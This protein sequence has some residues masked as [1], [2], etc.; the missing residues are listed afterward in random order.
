MRQSIALA[1]RNMRLTPISNIVNDITNPSLGMGAS[2][3][4]IDLSSIASIIRIEK[5]G[6]N[7]TLALTS[8]V[9]GKRTLVVK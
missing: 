8:G 5:T 2:G 3:A 7:V 1:T 6:G 9:S 4:R